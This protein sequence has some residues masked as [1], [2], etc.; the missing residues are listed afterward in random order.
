MKLAS[1]RLNK[2]NEYFKLYDYGING[3]NQ[4]LF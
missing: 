4:T 2:I 3:F 1:V